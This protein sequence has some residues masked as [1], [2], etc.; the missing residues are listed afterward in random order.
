MLTTSSLYFASV[1]ATMLQADAVV[2]SPSHPMFC[3]SP[4]TREWVIVNPANPNGPVLG[5]GSFKEGKT[6]EQI[7]DE[8]E[9]D[10]LPATLLSWLDYVEDAQKYVAEHPHLA[11]TEQQRLALAPDKTIGP[12]MPEVQW[13]QDAPYN[14][15]CPTGCPTGCVA[16]AV[17]QIMYYYKYP[18][19]G[20]GQHSYNWNGERLGVNFAEQTYNWDLMFDR[21]DARIH[22]EEQ[23]DE[24]AKLSYHVGVSVDMGYAPGGSGAYSQSVPGALSQYF[25]YNPYASLIDR[26]YMG[27]DVWSYYVQRDLAAGRPVYMS[28]V[29]ST[30][31]GHAFLLDGVNTQGYYHVN[32]GWGGAYN[33]WFDI[34]VMHPEGVG[35]GA[36]A[37]VDG[38]QWS[39]S[40]VVGL[41]PEVPA[42]STYVTSV[43]AY[44]LDAQMEDGGVHINDWLLN[45]SY[46]STTGSLYLDLMQG[47]ELIDRQQIAE[48]Q[49]MRFWREV[50]IDYTYQLPEGIED[51]EYR[52]YQSMRNQDGLWSRVHGWRPVPDYIT[53]QVQDGQVTEVDLTHLVTK[54]SAQEI[55]IGELYAGRTS[56]IKAL[57]TNE[58]QETY[59]GYYALIWFYSEKDYEF[60]EGTEIVTLAP[61]ES[62]WV[63]FH[64]NIKGFGDFEAVIKAGSIGDYEEHL[65]DVEGS[66]MVLHVENDG[67]F[68]SVLSLTESPYV[69]GGDCEVNGTITLAVP[70]RNEGEAYNGEMLVKLFADQKLSKE[71]MSSTNTF[72]VGSDQEATGMV[73]VVLDKAQAKHSYFAVA[74]T[75]R[76]DD[77]VQLGGQTN[78]LK[79]NVYEEG[80]FSGIEQ[81]QNDEDDAKAIRRDL[82]GRPLSNDSQQGFEIRNGHIYLK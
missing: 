41:Q 31:D 43:L 72:T 34:S 11:V 24:V 15:Y 40:V 74:Y 67:T 33:G 56:T 38:F 29:N 16:T 80:H 73:D 19:Q 6:A 75:R 62:Q 18:E 71:V 82:F 47:D 51:G 42:D 5:Y 54:L 22:T 48:E 13:N 20:I 7:L 1:A 44:Y 65:A 81:V 21:Y 2:Q 45:T 17:A 59:A 52:L 28:A 63:I 79:I 32:W 23:A 69:Q 4:H 25:G 35:I 68:G 8:I 49:K 57:V 37:S 12:L 10:Q 61:G 36:S 64:P 30:N 27:L 55:E 39:Q 76:G 9:Q 3:A 14:R 66:E 77:F 53:L 70:V 26:G 60:V 50:G 58:G 78:K 46:N